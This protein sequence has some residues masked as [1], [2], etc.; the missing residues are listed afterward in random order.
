MKETVDL[1]ARQLPDWGRPSAH[2]RALAILSTMVGA[3]MLARS[4]DDPKLSD[5]LR[6]AALKHSTPHSS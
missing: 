4:V 3:L 1:V 5:A 6:S 2:E